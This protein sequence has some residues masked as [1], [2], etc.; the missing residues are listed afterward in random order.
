VTTDRFPVQW[1]LSQPATKNR[2]RGPFKSTQSRSFERLRAEIG[3]LGAAEPQITCNL[4]INSRGIFF[5]DEGRMD[6]PG[7]A[8][9][10]KMRG[11]KL[12]FACDRYRDV[13]HNAHAIALTIEAIR[14]IDRW[15]SSQMRDQAFTG[16]AALPP[17]APPRISPWRVALRLGSGPV[18][19]EDV[20]KRHRELAFEAH[21]DRGGDHDTI[22]HLNQALA[23]A[24]AEL[25]G[26]AG[27]Y[28]GAS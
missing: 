27:R 8:V 23:D 3:R 6:F 14:G 12:C 13:G 7:V 18:T 11:Q 28:P 15:G 10:F 22:V 26:D 4:P 21:P 5:V 1:P 17:P 9:Y 19:L 16:F 25:L 20:K 24:E 2:E